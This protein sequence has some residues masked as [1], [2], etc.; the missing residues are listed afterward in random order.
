MSEQRIPVK[1]PYR[2]VKRAE[3]A[4]QTR[5]RILKAAH[6]LFLSEGY[7][8]TTIARVAAEAGVVAK[9][10]HLAFGTKAKLLDGVIQRAVA[11][12]DEEQALAARPN[13][14]EMLAS[15]PDQLLEAF[16]SMITSIHER[17]AELFAAA[18]VAAA[19]DPEL[20]EL[21]S[22][23]LARRAKDFSHIVRTLQQHDALGSG[24]SAN[25][26]TALILVLASDASYRL[27]VRDLGW[28]V[29]RYRTWLVR[30]LRTV[31]IG[32]GQA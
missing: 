10:V 7:P 20:A 29:P 32:N 23:G 30:A 26:T 18:E 24:L 4:R 19:S 2:A 28:S 27:L 31:F 11:G 5:L 12:D 13:W 21:R 3:S 16:G 22:Q 9:T 17:T 8:A 14:Q 6:R 1:R 25:E 15:P